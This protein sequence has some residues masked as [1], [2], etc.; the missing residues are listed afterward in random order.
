MVDIEHYNDIDA[1]SQGLLIIAERF[2]FVVSGP[3]MDALTQ[4]LREIASDSEQPTELLSH[5][6]AWLLEVGRANASYR[7]LFTGLN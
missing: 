2:G 1:V 6:C 5:I 3:G 4:Y 7:A